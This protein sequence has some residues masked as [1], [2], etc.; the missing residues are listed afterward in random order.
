MNWRKQGLIY[1]PKV[2][3]P[4]VLSHACMP[5]PMHLGDDIYRVF[6]AARDD[7]NCSHTWFFDMRLREPFEILRVSPAPG[8]G[9]CFTT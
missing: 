3:P 6:Y 2:N 1:A 7:K 4:L 9:G 5:V 8:R